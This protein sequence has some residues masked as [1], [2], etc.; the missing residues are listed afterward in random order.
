MLN[1]LR[2][3]LK[4][5]MQKPTDFHLE[6]FRDVNGEETGFSKTEISLLIEIIEGTG[7]YDVVGRRW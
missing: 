7:K 6:P 5:H 4:R 3:K 1:H 2:E